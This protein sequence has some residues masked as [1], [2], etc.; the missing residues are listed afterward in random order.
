MVYTQINS[1]KNGS[2]TTQS[3]NLIIGNGYGTGTNS[4]TSGNLDIYGYVPSNG[5]T[6]L[7]N[8]TTTAFGVGIVHMF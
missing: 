8:T 2:G 3:G 6:G 4:N 5:L 7:P 1:A